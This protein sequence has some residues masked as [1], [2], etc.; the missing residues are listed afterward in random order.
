MVACL[1]GDAAPL[2]GRLVKIDKG[3]LGTIS[4]ERKPSY[5]AALSI[6]LL[7]FRDSQSFSYTYNPPVKEAAAD[8]WNISFTRFLDTTAPG[9]EYRFCLKGPVDAQYAVGIFDKASETVRGN[10]W[11]SV[12]PASRPVASVGMSFVT[13]SY[14]SSFGYGTA[15]PMFKYSRM[16]MSSNVMMDA[17]SGS[18][19]EEEMTDTKAAPEGAAEAEDII[20]VRKEFNGT[21]AWEPALRSDENGEVSFTFRTSDKL[22]TYVVQVFAH[23]KSF[24]NKTISKE[25]TVTLPVTISLIQPSYLYSSDR[26]MLRVGLSNSTSA[27]ISGKV[28]VRF[29]NGKD[30]KGRKRIIS[31]KDSRISIP[32]TAARRQNSR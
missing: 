1:Y 21:L 29:V 18:F 7:F 15:R 30:Y 14:D 8:T 23:D 26:Y 22:S 17:A 31:K 5:P 6:K 9:A 11:H 19:E 24:N 13:G 20:V 27:P 10:R 32:Q 2:E 12:S 28:Q 4:F 3:T 16:M 25:M